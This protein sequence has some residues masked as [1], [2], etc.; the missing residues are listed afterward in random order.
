MPGSCSTATDAL[1]LAFQALQHRQRLHLR[2][3]WERYTARCLVR[4]A[5]LRRGVRALDPLQG[6]VSVDAE[7]STKPLNP[8]LTRRHGCMTLLVA[9]QLSRHSVVR[10]RRRVFS[11]RRRRRRY[12][13]ASEGWCIRHGHSCTPDQRPLMRN[14]CVVQTHGYNCSIRPCTIALQE[15]RAAALLD[16]GA[17]NAASGA[18]RGVRGKHLFRE[19]GSGRR[20]VRQV[21]INSVT[22]LGQASWPDAA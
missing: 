15:L 7:G 19:L 12:S 5:A 18:S 21:G 20:Y 9:H 6:I 1:A 16:D 17:H 2:R 13:R 10:V 22:A 11:N 14:A 3:R 8:L 4:T